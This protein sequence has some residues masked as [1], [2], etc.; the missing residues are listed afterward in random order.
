MYEADES[1]FPSKPELRADNAKSNMGKI[2][3]SIVLF[4]ALFL[5]LF[6]ENYLFVIEVIAILLV[7]ELGHFLMMKYY[8]YQSMNMIFVPFLGTL[9]GNE[10]R[11]ISQKHKSVVSLMGPMPGILV[12]IGILSYFIGNPENE[13]FLEIALLLLCINVANLIPIDP[14]DGGHLLETLYF[15]NNDQIKMYF[16]LISSFIVIGLG[17]Y[18]DFFILMIFGFFMAFKVRGFQ[19]NQ[20]IHGNLE[21]IDFDYKKS[22]QDLSDKE[23]WTIR[24]VFLESNPKIRD[25]IPNEM[26]LWENEKLLVEQVRQ[27]LR[28]EIKIDLKTSQKILFTALY[29]ALVTVPA[30]LIYKNWEMIELFLFNGNL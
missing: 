16:T 13:L 25:I 17:F 21:D 4:M 27:L 5:T 14:L 18:L 9:S 8:G 28:S 26:E 1:I 29:V 15:P 11:K 3:L 19:K 23:Y 2:F 20:R 24:R 22:Y 6:S 12:G 7:H 10:S 30:V